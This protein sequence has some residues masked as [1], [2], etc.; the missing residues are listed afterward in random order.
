M[1]TA[2]YLGLIQHSISHVWHCFQRKICLL[3]IFVFQWYRK[4]G[5]EYG[6]NYTQGTKQQSYNAELIKILPISLPLVTEQKK[7]ASYLSNIDHLI[8]LHQRKLEK[9]KSFKKSLL[10]KLFVQ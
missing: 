8:T 6:L 3:R 2:H 7:I 4:V 5:E 1:E 10:E 9:M